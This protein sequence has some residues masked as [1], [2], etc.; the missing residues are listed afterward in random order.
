VSQGWAAW[1]EQ[2]DLAEYESRWDRLE[3]G[4]G[5]VH[6]EADLVCSYD[7]VRVLDAGCGMGRVAIELDRR[8]IE[9]VGVDLDE[10]FLAVARRRSPRQRWIHAD[11]AGG[12][13]D[14]PYDVVVMAGNVLLFARETDRAAIVANLA[15]HLRPGGRLISGSTL[16]RAAGGLTLAAYEQMCAAAGLEIEDRWST[17]EREPLAGDGTDSYAVVVARSPG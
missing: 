16:E 14:G 10:D 17:W 3:A 12:R 11:L 1:R 4:G 8:G 7:P 2:V 9:A 13:L 15:A 5:S 6:G